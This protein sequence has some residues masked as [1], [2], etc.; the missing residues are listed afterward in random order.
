MP[1]MVPLTEADVELLVRKDEWSNRGIEKLAAAFR[2]GK[3]NSLFGQLT[4][5]A[6]RSLQRQGNA[7]GDKPWGQYY[8]RSVGLVVRGGRSTLYPAPYY[9]VIGAEL[10]HHCPPSSLPAE[11]GALTVLTSS[12]VNL[13]DGGL[14]ALLPG[15]EFEAAKA[16]F[17]P[18]NPDLPR[19]EIDAKL[20]GKVMDESEKLN[21]CIVAVLTVHR[22][23]SVREAISDK[24]LGFI[25]PFLA[26]GAVFLGLHEGHGSEA[27]TDHVV[28][29]LSGTASRPIWEKVKPRPMVRV[30]ARPQ[31]LMYRLPKT[32]ERQDDLVESDRRQIVQLLSSMA[33]NSFS[34]GWRK[35]ATKAHVALV[36]NGRQAVVVAN[37]KHFEHPAQVTCAESAACI[38]T[39][40]L[41]WYM[42]PVIAVYS[43][44]YR[45][46]VN[47]DGAK[48]IRA[49]Q[50]CKNCTGM[51]ELR[52]PVL[53]YA[54]WPLRSSR[55]Q[56]VAIGRRKAARQ[57]MLLL[58]YFPAS[59]GEFACVTGALNTL[60][61]DTTHSEQEA[62]VHRGG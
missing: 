32:I 7:N 37:N 47:G 16:Y 62:Q 60:L 13:P 61:G 4:K 42:F 30:L 1:L 15:D 48:A 55:E 39:W 52:R 23:N 8:A 49:P 5:V 3:L 51:L 2:T 58:R 38:V 46:K 28:M 50:P 45:P 19:P 6:S 9:L 31:S 18:G 14:S 41:E 35:P 43:P 57:D 54:D 36:I 25:R 10:P 33:D 12:G 26:R 29:K 34:D 27:V 11:A 56:E 21:R 24:G 53:T 44:H 22:A 17:L 40:A 20:L 59:G